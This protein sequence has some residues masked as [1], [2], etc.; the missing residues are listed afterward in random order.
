MNKKRKR[1]PRTSII[2]LTILLIVA[3]FGLPYAMEFID[4]TSNYDEDDAVEVVIPQGS[5]GEDIG[6]ILK[7]KDLIRS[8]LIFRLKAKLSH[9]GDKMNYGTFTLYKGMC[10]DDIIKT[11]AGNYSYKETVTL[12]VPEGFSIE[13]IGKKCEELG[14]FTE[15]E[16]LSGVESYNH[17]YK[18]NDGVKYTLQ[19]YLYP[20][21]YEFFADASPYD[22]IEKLTGQYEKVKKQVKKDDIA[23]QRSWEDIMIIASLI[24]REALL[25]SEMRT[26]SGVIYNRLEIGMRLQV[27]AAVQY[28]VSD[29]YYDV[30]RIKYSDLEIESPYNT[31]RVDALPVGPICNPG[32]DAILAACNPEDHDYLY[33]HTD[34]NKND[35]SHIFTKSYE[36][37][38]NTQ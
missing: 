11:L 35:G 16:F 26:I 25:D 17:P 7:E 27:D 13:Q 22:V 38:M 36:E 19:G 28:A 32:I 30:S 37:H 31:Y 18:A 2:I 24:E 10:I 9:D 14:L 33:Y 23:V 21:T 4:A 20:E 29:G 15:S 1:R 34:T 12:T 6:R 5:T 3:I 8:T